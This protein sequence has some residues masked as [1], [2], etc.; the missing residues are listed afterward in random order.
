VV[1]RDLPANSEYYFQVATLQ[2][3]S[4][5]FSQLSP[6]SEPIEYKIVLRIFSD[7]TEQNR[8]R[9][10][11]R[12]M[13]TFQN[14]EISR[15][16]VKIW[17]NNEISQNYSVT[18]GIQTTK[19]N[20]E[21]FDLTSAF[22]VGK[23]TDESECF[24]R[25]LANSTCIKYSMFADRECCLMSSLDLHN[26]VYKVQHSAIGNLKSP[27]SSYVLENLKPNVA[28]N[29]QVEYRNMF[30]SVGVSNI[31]EV[32]QDEIEEEKESTT[33]PITTTITNTST[34]TTTSTTSTGVIQIDDIYDDYSD[35]DDITPVETNGEPT[36]TA[37]TTTSKT[38]SGDNDY[39]YYDFYSDLDD[40]IPPEKVTTTTKT[41]TASTTTTTATTTTFVKNDD[42]KTTIYN[43]DHNYDDYYDETE[44]ND[45]ATGRIIVLP[46]NNEAR[47]E[48]SINIDQPVAMKN[49][50]DKLN[51]KCLS[52]GDIFWKFNGMKLKSDN[53]LT[54]SGYEAAL[55]FDNL[56]RY[57]QGLYTCNLANDDTV[58]KTAKILI[59]G[60]NTL[61]KSNFILSSL[62]LMI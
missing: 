39:D 20:H 28:W 34:T 11:W 44:N 3:N 30:G 55:V 10:F 42:S 57:N 16:T 54:K 61:T 40:V 53:K 17:S 52:G 6:V 18:D 9:I 43:P 51:I 15:Y 5:E 19:V 37:S 24:E 14:H 50:G 35:L 62:V 33:S 36:S 32:I 8:V 23:V 27:A 22:S 12:Q 13:G 56:Q 1:L 7:K 38:K 21:Y 46:D 29:V 60:S 26:S 58:Y 41:K 25:C 4:Y 49:I 2:K 45:A 47:T 48:I 59:D 31:I